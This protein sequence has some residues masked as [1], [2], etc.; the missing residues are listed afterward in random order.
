M[1]IPDSFLNGPTLLA[2]GTASLGF[3]HHAVKK[4]RRSLEDKDIPLL[5][6]TGAFIFAAQMLNFPVI[7]GTSGHFL[8]GLLAVLIVGPWAGALT[9]ASVLILQCLLFQDGGLLAL[10]ANIFNMGILGTIG[11]YLIYLFL[12]KSFLS[13]RQAIFIAAWFSVVLGAAA[14][15]LELTVSGTAPL[16]LVLPA[17]VGIHSLIGIGEAVIT[18]TVWQIIKKWRSDLLYTSGKE[19]L[20]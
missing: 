3:L 19:V 13:E 5:G 6:I 2:T 8:G 20:S 15:A 7:A 16:T 17:M 1:H 4:C 9:M 11:S 18:I 12:K 10:G 14:A